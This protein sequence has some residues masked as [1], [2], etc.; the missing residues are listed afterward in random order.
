MNRFRF[1]FNTLAVLFFTLMVTT[2]AQAQATRTWVSGN[3]NDFN[4]CTTTAAPC[5]TFTGALAK[6]AAGGE[7][8]VAA[9][10]DFGPVTINKAITID[11]GGIGGSIT[12]SFANGIV[13][14]AG[15]LDTVRLRNLSINGVGSGINGI[16]YLSGKFLHVEKVTIQDFTTHGIDAN[17]GTNTGNLTVKDS[18]VNNCGVVGVRV[19]ANNGVATASLDNVRVQACQFGFDTLDGTSTISNSVVSH[20]TGIGIVAELASSINVESTVVSNNGTGISGFSGTAVI[21]LSNT[22][23][24]NNG[25]GISIAPGTTVA[26]FQNN[27]F[28]GNTIPGAPNVV[29]SQQ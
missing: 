25:T 6:T 28:A 4:T 12:A 29:L 11:G 2:L 9:P 21:R 19:Q 27:R 5:R 3:G 10:G 16:R 26:T 14:I 13:V 7:I 23:V 8:S 18:Y 17:L 15:G 1:T 22:D 20:N 24:F